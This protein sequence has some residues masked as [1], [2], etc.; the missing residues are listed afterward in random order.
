MNLAVGVDAGGTSTRAWVVDS[1]GHVLGQGGAGGGNPNSHPPESAAEAMVEATEAAM[2]GLD[3]TE[4]RAWVIGMAGRSKLTDPDVAAVFERAWARL[5]FPHA[6]RP[7][8]VTDAEAAFVSATAEPDGTVLVA[9]TGSIAGRIRGRSMVSTVGGY[10][11]LLGDEGSGFWLGR[12]AVR[13]ALDV[14]SGVHPPSALADAVLDATGVN[15]TAPDAAYRLI[16]AVNA[17]PPVH[18]ARYAPLVSSAH[19]E[20]DP[21][22]V[23]I[24]EH[25]ARL[26]TDTALAARDPGER[27]P[28]VLVGSVLGEGSPVGAAVR[29][30][31]RATGDI[32]VLSSDSGVRGAAWLAALEAFGPDTARP[33]TSTV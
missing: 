6:P 4:V 10:G 7:R 31:L 2:A 16:T 5:G 14:L 20:G 32:P 28:V 18:L 27:T 25:A 29:T 24:V 11:W 3:P 13:T 33:R 1:T 17:E 19:A 22:A 23:S 26:L 15:P 9:G 12:Q 30:A 21:A 8:L